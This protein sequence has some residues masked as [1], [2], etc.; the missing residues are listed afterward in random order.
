MPYQALTA[1]IAALCMASG[2]G[3]EGTSSG[4]TRALAAHGAALVD[5]FG[6]VHRPFDD[7]QVR[8]IVLIFTL[9]DCPIANSYVPELNRLHA[10]YEARGVRLFLMQVDPDLSVAGAQEVA[11]QFEIK[12]PV[13]LDRRHEWVRK[14]GATATPEAAVLAPEGTLLYLGR[15][16]NRYVG[17]GKR[18]EQVTE[19][20][21]RDTLDA[22][23]ADRP[24]PRPRTQAIGCPI[25]L[26]PQGD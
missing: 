4:G 2:C 12:A 22:V 11:R 3:Q 16:D 5:V 1:A 24:I 9:P 15:I 13:V 19:R 21:L 6:A 14:V 10:E 7:P 23:L 20:D 25:P 17:F 8:A 18:R 26:S